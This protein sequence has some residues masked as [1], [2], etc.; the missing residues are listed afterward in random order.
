V[1]PD[2]SVQIA[3]PLTD[4]L[5]VLQMLKY[6]ID[7]IQPGWTFT[8]T[9]FITAASAVPAWVIAFKSSAW[10]ARRKASAQE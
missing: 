10:I 8:L 9:A 5:F 1:L 2:Y 6:V 3:A 4:L 7:G